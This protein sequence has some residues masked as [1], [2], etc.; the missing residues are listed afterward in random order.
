MQ[1]EYS[2]IVTQNIFNVA[3]KFQ[4]FF[5][6]EKLPY[7]T[8]HFFIIMNPYYKIVQIE[9]GNFKAKIYTAQLILNPFKNRAQ[10]IPFI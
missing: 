8:V 3:K 6:L 2:K 7:I 9:Y 1:L 4:L 5:V 10:I